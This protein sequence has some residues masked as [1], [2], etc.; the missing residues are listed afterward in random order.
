MKIGID[1]DNVTFDTVTP[2]LQKLNALY[3]TEFELE[4]VDYYS[5]E[6]SLGLDI[7][8]VLKVVEEITAMSEVPIMPG[9]KQVLGWLQLVCSPLY[10]ISDRPTRHY[11]STYN[12]LGKVGLSDN[13]MILTNRIE[14]KTL[15]TK[16][17]YVNALGI[18]VFIDDKPGLIL[19]LLEETDCHVIVFE[20]PWNREMK[21]PAQYHGRIDFMH[22]WGELR[23]F[24]LVRLRSD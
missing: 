16:A 5:L 13:V 24:F 3:G 12:Q 20:R 2:M 14:N 19:S 17:H 18:D 22:H 1:I 10:F 6:K 23:D 8:A 4:D 15:R 21:L 7:D 9:A 11:S